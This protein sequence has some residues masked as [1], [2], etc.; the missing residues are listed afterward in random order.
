MGRTNSRAFRTYFESACSFPHF[1]AQSSFPS[2]RLGETEEGGRDQT[3]HH[4]KGW[5]NPQKQKKK[6]QA[7]HRRLEVPTRLSKRGPAS[8]PRRQ[9]KGAACPSG[10]APRSKCKRGARSA[11]GR[12]HSAFCR[13]VHAPSSPERGRLERVGGGVG[14]SR[15]VGHAEETVR[16]A[17]HLEN[18]ARAHRRHSRQTSV[19]ERHLFCF[20]LL[21]KHR[22]RPLSVPTAPRALGKRR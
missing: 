21:W 22:T 8:H 16:L 2:F 17:S 11:F 14:P 20:P 13:Q 7:R 19:F 12:R 18:P 6:E 4:K 9:R 10:P 3:S 5:R 15:E 1:V